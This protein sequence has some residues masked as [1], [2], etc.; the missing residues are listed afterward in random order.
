MFVTPYHGVETEL[1]GQDVAAGQ[2]VG[3]AVALS[4]IAQAEQQQSHHSLH[5]QSH[6]LLHNRG[7]SRYTFSQYSSIPSS[8][9]FPDLVDLRKQKK[10]VLSYKKFVSVDKT[11]S[12]II[13]QLP[14]LDNVKLNYNITE[15]CFYCDLSRVYPTFS[16]R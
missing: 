7:Q 13:Q 12:E 16:L 11:V 14:K 10:K 4:G 1:L 2:A 3:L 5:S 15:I 8:G 6:H 9:Y